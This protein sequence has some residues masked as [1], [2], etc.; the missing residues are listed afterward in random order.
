MSVSETDRDAHLGLRD[1]DAVVVTGAAR[2]IGRAI[3]QLLAERGARIAVLDVGD[4]G[5]ETAELC[6]AAGSDARFFR[7]DVSDEAAVQTAAKKVADHFGPPFGLVND[8]GVF[9]RYTLIDTPLEEWNR[10]LSVNLTGTFLVTRT[11]APLMLDAG[12]GA[13]VNISSGVALSSNRRAGAYGATKAGIVSLTRTFALELAPSIRVNTVL[14]GVTETHMPLEGTDID[15]LRSRGAQ[16]PLGRIG[17][18]EDIARA[19]AFLLGPD[20][21]YITG[22]GISVNG[23]RSMVP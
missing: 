18:V 16:I 9:P 21:S 6:K 8:A 3:A 22:Q 1:G 5:E 23:G 15:E 19:A 14:P 10:V 17:A 2:G 20:A 4:G 7:C 13:I 12:R 11:F